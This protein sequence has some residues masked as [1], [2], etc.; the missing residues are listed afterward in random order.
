MRLTLRTLLAYLDNTLDAEHAESIRVKLTESGFATQLVQRI[1]AS[2]ANAQLSAPP[3]DS[4]NPISE[5][6]LMSEYLDSTLSPEQI[7]EIERACLESEPHLAEAASCHQILTMALGQPAEV[8]DDL[9]SRIYEIGTTKADRG[10]TSMNFS[11][12]N[13]PAPGEPLPGVGTSTPPFSGPP[14]AG[15]PPVV[16]HSEPSQD[17]IPTIDLPPESDFDSG[18]DEARVPVQPVGA[19][20]SGVF[21]AVT[22]MRQ[23]EA[24]QEEQGKNGQAIA[25]SRTRQQIERSDLFSDSVR[26]SRITPWLVS[27]ALAG[28]LLFAIVQIFNPLLRGDAVAVNDEEKL[29]ESVGIP[30]AVPP[31]TKDEVVVP[32]DAAP[33]MVEV[34]TPGRNLDRSKSEPVSAANL[35][36]P[37]PD[38]DAT[39]DVATN[40]EPPTRAEMSD[41]DAGLPTEETPD[42]TGTANPTTSVEPTERAETDMQPDPTT[43]AD[44]D[45]AETSET[46]MQ[47]APAVESVA[48]NPPDASA[49][50][51][52]KQPQPPAAATPSIGTLLDKN[53][54]VIVPPA[55][56]AGES[57]WKQL[58][59]DSPVPVD[60]TIWC[61]PEFRAEIQTDS[62]YQVHLIG[63]VNVMWQNEQ[64]DSDQPNS[65]QPNSD[66]PNSDQP[67]SDQP[68]AELNLL[69]GR[70]TVQ[71]TASDVVLPLD[72]AGE[73][74]TVT[75]PVEGTKLGVDVRFVREPGADPLKAENHKRIV[76]LIAAN[77]AVQL[78]TP[79]GDVDL[80]AGS[81]WLSMESEPARVAELDLPPTWMDPE[82]EQ[83]GSL[84][85]EAKDALLDLLR[86]RPLMPALREALPFR[87]SEVGALAAK[88]MLC[89]GAADV[90][91]GVDGI[92]SQPKQ[93]TFWDSHFQAVKRM[94]DQSVESAQTVQDAITRM[95]AA[96]SNTLFKLLTG[97][98]QPELVEGKDIQLVDWL[99]AT[100]MSVRVLAIENLRQ[101]TGT[102]LYFRAEEDNAVRRVSVIK[103]WTA[104]QRKGDIRWQT[105]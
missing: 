34:G 105:Q 99:D 52:P 33:P 36:A 44:P 12:L 58:P 25:G 66:Q 89:L 60:T 50:E 13:V 51:E 63:P 17:A 88:T 65:D 61:A 70:F 62:G 64:P 9:R 30:A 45:I 77:Q 104:R 4:V 102:T 56:N 29:S 38:D 3:P 39:T 74:V 69:S 54:L 84:D 67:N 68:S 97:F 80:P 28:V 27:L 15:P 55:K 23:T 20:D 86:D 95:D 85:A 81:K 103:K 24:M 40:D 90:Y 8:S 96:E 83:P 78:A 42:S 31:P 47:P 21:D 72:V 19:G 7:A 1:R 26:P 49:I 91:F 5:A 82:I 6:N 18:A 94:V 73:V 14:V 53:S 79:N 87:R 71:S 93:R 41:S 92:F 46:G 10:S 48:S 2:L 11:G 43:P 37:S 32:P 75:M 35:P 59:G 101:I 16:Q 98:S 22:R 100:S 76:S 57:D